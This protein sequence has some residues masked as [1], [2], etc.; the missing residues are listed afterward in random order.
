MDYTK[1]L[2]LSYYKKVA[3]INEPHQIYLVQHQSSGK[4]FVEKIL[5]VFNI[6]VYE[7]LQAHPILGTPQII[8]FCENE[9]KLT[10]IEE[11]IPGISLQEKM[12]SHA[13]TAE[14]IAHYGIN[15]CEIIH[16]LHSMN[17][18]IIHRDIKPSNIILTGYDNVVLLDFNAAKFFSEKS[19]S[20]TVLLG[21]HG[22]AAPEQYGFGASSV[23]TDIYSI[24]VLLKELVTS[25]PTQCHLFDKIIKRCTQMKPSDRYHSVSEL[26]NDL[27]KIHP[28]IHSL[29]A[30]SN[31]S[32]LPPGYRSHTPWKMLLASICYLLIFYLCLTLEV[33]NVSGIGIWINRIFC[34][35]M[36]LSIVFGCFNYLDVQRFLPLCKHPN[37][38]VHYIGIV[39]LDFSMTFI[40]LLILTIIT[41]RFITVP[42]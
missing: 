21:T 7:T 32:Y 2:A 35:A 18:P 22:Y 40:L 42:L 3:V 23:Q 41:A 14:S 33:E 34:L 29:K 25:M 15:L 19:Q 6:D 38:I 17:P 28:F 20:D 30:T 4:F 10:L 16:R 31:I 39:L 37:R 12:D 8:D 9:N 11:Y 36:M 1:R 5:D 26:Q 13:L 24:G 27:Q